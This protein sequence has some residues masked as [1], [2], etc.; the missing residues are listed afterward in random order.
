MFKFFKRCRDKIRYCGSKYIIEPK[1]RLFYISE[2]GQNILICKVP[3]KIIEIKM[4]RPFGK[5]IYGKN[6][7]NLGVGDIFKIT[8][9]NFDVTPTMSILQRTVQNTET[10]ICYKGNGTFEELKKDSV[11]SRKAYITVYRAY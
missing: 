2:D 6:I 7:I 3:E 1:Y 9:H 4:H 5:D 10:Y 8:V 11:S